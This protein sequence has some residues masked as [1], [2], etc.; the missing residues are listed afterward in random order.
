M[1]FKIAMVSPADI[2]YE[3]S[4]CTLRYA[5]RVKHIQNHAR[6]NVEQKGLIEGFE[7]EIADLQ[8][9]VYLLSL[10]EQKPTKQK[11]K[12]NTEAKLEEL[13]KC[14]EELQKT[15]LVIKILNNSLTTLYFYL[16]KR[17][18]I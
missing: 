11:K 8:Q 3:E 6:I 13:R 4:I 14:E 1:L 12:A 10:Q 16:E 9:K 2:D 5:A 7:Q 17:R 15:E 18:M